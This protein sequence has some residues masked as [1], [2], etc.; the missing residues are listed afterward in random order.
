MCMRRC[1]H[2]SIAT[3]GSLVPKRDVDMRDE[4]FKRAPLPSRASPAVEVL[5]EKSA[6]KRNIK[7]LCVFTQQSPLGVSFRLNATYEWSDDTGSFSC[8]RCEKSYI[9][10]A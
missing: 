6:A 10:F 3:G 9:K 7:W 2:V 8:L 5:H 4:V 1:T